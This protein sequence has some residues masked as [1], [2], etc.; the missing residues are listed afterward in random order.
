MSGI[1]FVY[2]NLDKEVI[3]KMVKDMSAALISLAGK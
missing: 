3:E 2:V 1:K